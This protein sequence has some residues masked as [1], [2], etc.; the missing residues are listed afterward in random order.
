VI[1]SHSKRFIFIKTRKTA[2]STLQKAFAFA[3]RPGDILISTAAIL[4]PWARTSPRPR[5]RNPHLGKH[6]IIK[7]FPREWREYTKITVERNPLD[8]TVSLYWWENRELH[9]RPSFEQWLETKEDFRLSDF[10]RYGSKAGKVLADQVILFEDLQAGY[11]RCCETL[12]LEIF[13]LGK[14]KSGIR[15]SGDRTT[16]YYNE[17]TL[18]RMRRVFHREM[19]AFGYSF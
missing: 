3:C 1:V 9:P 2:G 7:H 12:D 14:E 5:E 16:D 15:S 18:E 13:P 19:S 11:A 8:K 4:P 17:A 10:H 6:W